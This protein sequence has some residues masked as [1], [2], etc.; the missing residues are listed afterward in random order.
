MRRDIEAE[1]RRANRPILVVIDD[2]DRLDPSEL[3]LLF[4]LIRL[5]GRLPNVF[6]LLA[7]DEQTLLDALSRT[8]LIGTD[9]PRRS[10]DYLEKI[11]QIRID[12]PPLRAE[13]VESWVDRE[14]KELA[15]RHSIEIDDDFTQRFSRA[16]FGHIRSRLH[17]PRAINR[18]IAQ[19]DSFL[20]QVTGEVDLVDFLVLTW[21]RT[22]EPLVYGALIENRGRLLGELDVSMPTLASGRDR[23]VESDHAFWNA[24]FACAKV[25]QTRVSGV[26]DVLGQIFP[27]FAYEWSENK[28]RFSPPKSSP[29]RIANA[30]YFDRYFALGVPED[31]LPDQ[32]VAA[33]SLQIVERREGEERRLLEAALPTRSELI[34]SK[35]QNQW[36]AGEPGGLEALDWLA[37]NFEQFP[38]HRDPTDARNRARWLGGKLYEGLQGEEPVQFLRS[39][40]PDP[41]VIA[42]CGALVG[43]LMH[44]REQRSRA[45][46]DSFLVAERAFGD[47]LKTAFEAQGSTNPLQIPADLWQRIGLWDR[48]D[49]AGPKEWVEARISTGAWALLDLLARLVNTSTTVGV[50]D[51][52]T[53]IED[54]D[55]DFVDRIVGLDR[56]YTTL[57]EEIVASRGRAERGGLATDDNRRD[58]VLAVLR[59]RRSSQ[60]GGP[61]EA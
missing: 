57:D 51:P 39:V 55:L 38:D 41:P 14:I 23:D 31:D 49:P 4:K 33:A 2:V 44:D 16:Y 61:D 56:V 20:A 42:F 7:Y 48:I 24:F 37:R 36:V 22:S 43:G 8:G 47:I 46:A 29:R 45:V 9:N 3:L 11:I 50:E 12:I 53:R 54:L 15:A 19:V 35:L 58:F 18:Y 6:Y 30:D 27:R 1:L 10:I 40:P 34:L 26:A 59:S 21:L 32:L 25:E 5:V 28:Q 52:V 60:Q 17:T 13:Q